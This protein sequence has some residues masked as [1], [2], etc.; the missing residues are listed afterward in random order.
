MRVG[1]PHA[2]KVLRFKFDRAR[3]SRASDSSLIVF[4]LAGRATGAGDD[5]T[6]V[7]T[8]VAKPHR[9]APA[10]GSD[11]ARRVTAPALESDRQRIRPAY[12]AR[13]I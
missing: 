7:L 1:T 3:L 12:D 11:D 8:E 4:E 2:S 6:G 5:V 13:R 10:P 9:K